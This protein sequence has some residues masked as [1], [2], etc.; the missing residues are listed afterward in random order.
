MEI[1]ELLINANPPQAPGRPPVLAHSL[2]QDISQW[3]ECFSIMV[4]I[5]CTRFP[6]KAP[7]LWA[8]Q[9]TIMRAERNYEGKQWVMYDHQFR[10]Q[11]LMKNGQ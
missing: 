1:A 4:A 6:E 2:V 8:Y 7:E 5:V 3:V 9:A 10:R 11:A